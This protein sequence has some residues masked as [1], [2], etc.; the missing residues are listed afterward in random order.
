[1][2]LTVI[3]FAGCFND[4]KDDNNTSGETIE[5]CMDVNASNYDAEA[6]TDNGTCVYDVTFQVD[7]IPE[8]PGTVTVFGSMNNWNSSEFTMTDLGLSGIYSITL[9]LPKGTYQY[10]FSYNSTS[11]SIPDVG[12]GGTCD[13]VT[14]PDF[15]NRGILVDGPVTTPVLILGECS[16]NVGCTDPVASNYSATATL[17]NGTCIY[18]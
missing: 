14:D 16:S 6:N 12:S 5:G 18:D 17:N 9:Q 11:E 8:T 13:V 2:L 10:L 1:M 4:G 7:I 3:L 15:N